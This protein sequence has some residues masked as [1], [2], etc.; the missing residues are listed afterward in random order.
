[1]EG[2][3]KTFLSVANIKVVAK[4]SAIPLANFAIKFAVAGATII[5]SEILD[6]CI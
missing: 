2:A 5:S 3:N 6:N 1:M 4:S